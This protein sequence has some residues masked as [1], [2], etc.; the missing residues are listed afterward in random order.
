ML[1]YCCFKSSCCVLSP[2]AREGCYA[3]QALS[4]EQVSVYLLVRVLCAHKLHACMC[5]VL[6]ST[7]SSLPTQ[8]L[9]AKY[10]IATSSV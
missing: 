5:L 3:L 6:N 4:S 7:A 1:L 10:S 9:H 2:A 8:S